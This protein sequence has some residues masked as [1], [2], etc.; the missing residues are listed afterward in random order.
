MA[1]GTKDQ[2]PMNPMDFWKQWGETS[3]KMWSN[4]LDGGK[5]TYGRSL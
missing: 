3:T 4:I 1:E 2:G 5:G